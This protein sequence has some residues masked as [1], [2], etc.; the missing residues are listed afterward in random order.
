MSTFAR[1]VPCVRLSETLSRD[2]RAHLKHLSVSEVQRNFVNIENN[3][4]GCKSQEHLR[5]MSAGTNTHEEIRPVALMS[6]GYYVTV[7][8]LNI[9]LYNPADIGVT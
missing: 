1:I 2:F 6:V 3:L 7:V 4:N 9:S 5:S 8:S